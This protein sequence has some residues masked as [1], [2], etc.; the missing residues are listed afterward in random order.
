[1]ANL[2][3]QLLRAA[4]PSSRRT[5]RVPRRRAR[6]QVK[7]LEDRL[8]PAV[9]NV[10]TLVDSLNPGPGLTSLRSAIQQVNTG[11]DTTNTINLTLPGTYKITL[12]GTQGE[13]DNA[14]GEFSILPSAG[15]VTIANTS[16]GSVVV[17]GNHLNR[18]F[19]INWQNTDNP[20]TKFLV[21]FQGF[22]I[23]NG[24][25]F[26]PAFPDGPTSSGGGIRDQGNTSLTLTNITLTNN[27]ASADGGGVSMENAASTPWTLTLNNTT[28]SNNHAGDAGGGVET[29]GV[30]NVIIN[31]GSLTGNT[32]L[33]QGAAVWLDAI[34]DG[35]ASVLIN[36]PGTGYT[37]PTLTFSAPQNA[38]GTTATG[39]ATLTGGV[40]TAVTITNPGSG[41]TLAPTVTINDPTVSVAKIID[42]NPASPDQLL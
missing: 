35:V 27:I 34:P 30:G 20:A 22:T 36:N 28:V 17:D 25:A 31:G 14:A 41:Y 12:A 33:N 16:G 5:V 13:T 6:L 24:D 42:A 39:T 29:D 11:T 2:F 3:R 23:Q 7:P 4:S 26:D 18:V 40:I 1:M 37:A 21:T 15:N 38:G 32:T 10:N 8:V 9:I 19:D